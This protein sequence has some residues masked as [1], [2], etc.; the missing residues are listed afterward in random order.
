MNEKVCMSE[1]RGQYV[2]VSNDLT[3]ICMNTFHKS[4]FGISF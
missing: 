2:L 4:I 3:I 1:N